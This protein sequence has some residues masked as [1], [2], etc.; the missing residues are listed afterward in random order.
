[1]LLV[2]GQTF[3]GPSAGGRWNGVQNALGNVSGIVAPVITGWLVDRSGG[4]GLAFAVAAGVSIVGVIAWVFLVG[5]VRTIDWT[6]R[7]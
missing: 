7:V 2:V 3:A 1:M 5:T 4:F 6:R